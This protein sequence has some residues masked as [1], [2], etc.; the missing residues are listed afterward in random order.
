MN[1]IK[2]K[3]GVLEMLSLLLLG[4]WEVPAEKRREDG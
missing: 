2:G 1:L 4:R 3:D